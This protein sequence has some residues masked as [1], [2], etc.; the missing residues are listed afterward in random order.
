MAD[1]GSQYTTEELKTMKRNAGNKNMSYDSQISMLETAYNDIQTL[2]G[3]YKSVQKSEAEYFADKTGWTNRKKL[4]WNGNTYNSYKNDKNSMTA[5]TG[6]YYTNVLDA[7]ADKILKKQS[8]LRT[9]KA[10]NGAWYEK[11][12]AWLSARLNDVKAKVN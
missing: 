5:E 3:Q 4:S 8:E 2:K 1:D 12:S 6:N 10:N 7:A 9:Q 11:V